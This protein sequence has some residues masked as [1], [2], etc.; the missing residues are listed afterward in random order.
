MSL[1]RHLAGGLACLAL[2]ASAAA[3]RADAPPDPLRLVPNQASLLLEIKQPR[4]LAES[5]TRLDLF[6]QLQT[7]PTFR[8]FFDSTAYRRFYQLIAYYDKQL[9]AQWP[10]LLDKLAGGGAVVAVKT[11]EP[12][13]AP[14]WLVLQG[15]DEALARKFAELGLQVL[16]QELARQ[17]SKDKV[18]K[19]EYRKLPTVRA[20][21]EFHAAVIGSAII[22]ANNEAGLHAALDCH[23]DGGKKSLAK[24]ASIANA[25]KLLPAGPL[26]TAW[27]DLET[28]R[29]NEQVKQA[30]EKGRDPNL[31]VLFGGWLDAARRSPYLAAGLYRDQDDFVLRLRMPAGRDGMGPEVALHAAPPGQPGC[32]PLLEPKGVLY[33]Q[34]FYLDVARFWNDRKDL[35]TE[36][37][38]K[39]IEQADKNAG[40]AIAGL[41]L[42][43]V[44]GQAGS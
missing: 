32:R 4:Q 44:L 17:E 26:A 12:D 3:A 37:Q 1:S 8:E 24:V 25:R 34:S 21:K 6:K 27:L 23:L 30:F 41:K 43:K 5:V 33:S 18:E 2:L 39:Q 42:S 14:A 13:P 9:G 20:G 38:V 7:V 31:T 29:K 11:G 10:E 36:A 16:E 40:A 19:G 22:I 28:A 35:F 15:R